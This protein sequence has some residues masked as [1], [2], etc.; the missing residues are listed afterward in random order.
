ML[1][2]KSPPKDI[3]AAF[4]VSKKIFKQAIGALYKQR[5]ISLNGDSIN[6]VEP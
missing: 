2:D 3:Y 1:T 5:L 6:L 4:G